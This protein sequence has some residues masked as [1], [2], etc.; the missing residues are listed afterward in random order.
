MAC[1][2][3]IVYT[4]KKGDLILFQPSMLIVN[5]ELSRGEPWIYA[6]TLAAIVECSCR[7]MR[8]NV[9]TYETT[10]KCKFYDDRNVE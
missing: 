4:S 2:K 1:A 10:R 3:C 5:R 6:L 8:E 9:K 7:S